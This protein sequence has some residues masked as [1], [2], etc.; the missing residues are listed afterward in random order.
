MSQSRD[1]AVNDKTEIQL[2]PGDVI[3]VRGYGIF[4]PCVEANDKHEVLQAEGDVVYGMNEIVD[5]YTLVLAIMPIHLGS[6]CQ[7]AVCV[8]TPRGIA[9]TWSTLLFST[10]M[11]S[12]VLR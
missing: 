10:K 4:W 11:H 8:L 6:A 7:D 3:H 2:A 9:W 5:F 1:P 12:I